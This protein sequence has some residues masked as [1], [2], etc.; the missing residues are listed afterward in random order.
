MALPN[1]QMDF[2]LFLYLKMADFY[3]NPLKIVLPIVTPIFE[4]SKFFKNKCNKGKKHQDCCQ[5]KQ[6]LQIILIQ[7]IFSL[8][9]YSSSALWY[10]FC[11][12]L[13]HQSFFD[14]FYQFSQKL[15]ELIFPRINFIEHLTYDI[16]TNQIRS[17]DHYFNDLDM[18][19]DHH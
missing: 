3:K 4:F 11:F 1:I 14:F 2:I 15:I 10:V 9:T 5:I 18:I 17:K 19:S 7:W 16:N 8:K 12:I 13:L 6:P